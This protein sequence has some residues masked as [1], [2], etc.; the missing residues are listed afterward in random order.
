VP[1]LTSLADEAA[2]LN[3]HVVPSDEEQARSALGSRL[4]RSERS[5]RR[6]RSF[7]ETGPSLEYRG[8]R[9]GAEEGSRDT[10]ARDPL[11]RRRT[12]TERP[13]PRTS[14]S[15]TSWT[16]DLAEL[17]RQRALA[18]LGGEADLAERQHA[19]GRLTLA[20]RLDGLVDRS[21]FVPLG[22][23]LDLPWEDLAANSRPPVLVGTA[24]VAGRRI[25]VLGTDVTAPSAPDDHLDS[26]VRSVCDLAPAIGAPVVMLLDGVGEH[27][28]GDTTPPGRAPLPP[29]G[30]LSAL[31]ALRRKVPLVTVAAGDVA[32][33]G[34]II[35]ASSHYSVMVRGRSRVST[36]ARSALTARASYPGRDAIAVD[37]SA[38]AGGLVDDAVDSEADAFELVRHVLAYLPSAAGRPLEQWPLDDASARDPA[39][40]D[41]LLP[42][43]PEQPYRIRDVLECILDSHS[44]LELRRGMGRSIVTGL[45]RLDGWAVA[46]LAS[47]PLYDA[48]ALTRA[49]ASKARRLVELA[50]TF[51]I[52]VVHLIDQPGVA[53]GPEAEADGALSAVVELLEAV[54]NASVPWCSVVL[55]PRHAWPDTALV[56]HSAPLRLRYRW[57]TGEWRSG[58]GS[59]P[60]HLGEVIAPSE[61]RDRLVAFAALAEGMVLPHE[62]S[63]LPAPGHDLFP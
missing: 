2:S 5:E 51:R 19:Q 56:P 11:L 50:E 48:G 18:T 52:P 63:L 46:I 53:S 40:L 60:G 31:V 17:A 43:E 54:K 61:T 57:A 47:D 1:Q 9:P 37:E 45:A 16:E 3:D 26:A 28:L 44:L 8:A 36:A 49:A 33:L 41:Q 25:V 23:A 39:D 27:Q 30:P 58:A 13:R 12:P 62:V 6:E 35:S 42:V 15:G 32:G 29:G 59:E 20:E 4:E 21:S 24:R 34:A 38:L 7:E 22:P 55:R 14:A 10:A